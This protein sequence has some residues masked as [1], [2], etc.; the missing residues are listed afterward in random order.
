MRHRIRTYIEQGHDNRHWSKYT[1]INI[2]FSFYLPICPS[3][4]LLGGVFCEQEKNKRK[5]NKTRNNNIQCSSTH[6]KMKKKKLR[7]I[8]QR[9]TKSE[10]LD[11]FALLSLRWEL[12]CFTRSA[13]FSIFAQQNDCWKFYVCERF[14]LFF[15]LSRRYFHETLLTASLFLYRVFFLFDS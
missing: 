15:F 7:A 5:K 2:Y 9:S 6:K 12:K 4:S 13:N 11:C 10:P 14:S 8:E 1:H 3:V